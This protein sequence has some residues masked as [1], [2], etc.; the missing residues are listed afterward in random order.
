MFDQIVVSARNTLLRGSQPLVGALECQAHVL[1]M[2]RHYGSDPG[3]RAGPVPHV[4]L[5]FGHHATKRVQPIDDIS[6]LVDKL[7][8]VRRWRGRSSHEELG[9]WRLPVRPRAAA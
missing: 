4:T 9:R 3:D 7:V 8:L 1:D 6:W 2:V 5:G